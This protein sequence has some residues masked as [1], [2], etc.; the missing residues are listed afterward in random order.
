[1][2][3]TSY[4]TSATV[5]LTGATKSGGS[6][7]CGLGCGCVSGLLLLLGVAGLIG[8]QP[9]LAMPGLILGGMG[10]VLTIYLLAQAKQAAT[11]DVQ[12]TITPQQ[13]RFGERVSVRVQAAGRRRCRLTTGLIALRCREKAINRGGTSDTTYYHMVH[14]DQRPISAETDLTEGMVWGT[15]ESFEIPVG[16]PASFSG[17]NNFIQWHARVELGLKGPLMDIRGDHDFEVLPELT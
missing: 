7:G 5:D 13:A 3:G 16:L 10:A 8:R 14:D 6:T 11:V 15:E 2:N 4:S 12:V 9:G 17:R 1:M